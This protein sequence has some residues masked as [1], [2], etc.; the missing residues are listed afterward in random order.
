L[1]RAH[2]APEG[3]IDETVEGVAY[4]ILGQGIDW[5]Q[6]V[7][8]G[9]VIARDLCQG[10]RRKSEVCEPATVQHD[11]TEIEEQASGEQLV[12]FG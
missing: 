8:L 4:E 1:C 5:N 7:G 3:L 6:A 9:Q 2:G 12:M 10:K 11:K